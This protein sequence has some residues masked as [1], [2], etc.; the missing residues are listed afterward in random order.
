[1]PEPLASLLR[2]KSF[3]QIIGQ[4]HLIGVDKPFRKMIENKRLMSCILFGPNGCGKSSLMSV[5]SSFYKTF[6]FNATTFSTKELRKVIDSEDISVVQIDE[7][8]R[9]TATQADVLLPHIENGKIVFVGSTVENPFHTLRRS[10]LSRCQIFTLEPL[11]EKELMM[12]IVKGVKHYRE[13]QILIIDS[14]AVKYM[15]RVSCGD[16]R[17]ALCLLEMAKEISGDISLEAVKTIAPSK[18]V[19]YDEGFKY[20]YASAFQ[21]SIQH[22]DPHAAVYWLAKWLESGEDPRYIARR[23]L[24]SAAEDAAGNPICTAVAHAAY[25]A[26]CEVGRPEC[27]IV[28]SQATV[29]V[30]SSVRDKSA[31]IAIWS[32]LKDVREGVDVQVPVSMKDSHYPG[33]E[34]LGFG[35]YHDGMNQSAYVGVNKKY[36]FPKGTVD[37]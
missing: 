11:S 28:L 23:L 25:T 13:K 18:Y 9:L 29:L 34:K 37:K 22:S 21:G 19:I 7:C 3:D 15:A 27:D 35:A 2:P 12:L 30:A 26:A 33:A 31:A 5:I 36:Y 32:A 24:V 14:D 16:G 1:M 17:K 6:S 20:D 8:Y 4:S 10:L